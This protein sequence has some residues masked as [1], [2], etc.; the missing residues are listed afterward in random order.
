M[1]EVPPVRRLAGFAEHEIA[2]GCA[3]FTV[4]L[5]LHDAKPFFLLPSFKL[6]VTSYE[7]GRKPV[8][9]ICVEASLPATFTPEPFQ[10]YL[11]VRLGLK[12]DPLALAVTGSPA[13]TSFGCTEQAALTEIPGA[14]PPNIKLRPVCSLR[15]RISVFG[16]DGGPYE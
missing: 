3:S 9:S 13:K 2:G 8:V 1:V 11:T 4:N 7:P 12:L 14:P 6:A 15:P 5:A 16:T 10:L